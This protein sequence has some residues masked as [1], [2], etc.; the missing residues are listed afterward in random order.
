MVE[1]SDSMATEV[2]DWKVEHR[3]KCQ[4]FNEWCEAEGVKMPK[5]EYPGYFDG[6]LVGMRATAPIEHREAFIG[7]PYKMLITC[8]GA[9]L[10]P[11]LGG[12]IAENPDIFSDSKGDWEQLTLVLVL[13]YE[14][15]KGEESY[16]KPYL[17]LMPDVKF[18]CNWPEDM[19]SA[20]VDHGLIK[21]AGDYKT[22]LESEWAEFCEMMGRYPDV[23]QASTID[24]DLFYKFY[25]QVCTR[26]FG[27]GL[28]STALIPMADNCNHSDVSVVQEI[29]HKGLHLTSERGENYFTKTKYMN[30]FSLNYDQD[31]YQNDTDK[32]KRVKGYFN[33]ANYESNKKFQSVEQIKEGL[34]SGIQ[35]WDVPCIRDQYIEDNDTE[36]E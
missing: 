11:V 22:E 14:Y 35:I 24:P 34:A 30:D 23:F 26:C 27:W 31:E 12:I 7:I 15:Q 2:E 13:I 18:M 32:T 33:K 36:E 4:V 21:H 6:G 28:P 19:I 8:R 1:A 29:V 9:Q 25:A 10:H 16:W 20:T 5:L 3:R 17:D